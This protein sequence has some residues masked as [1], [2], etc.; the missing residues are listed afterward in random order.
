MEWEYDVDYMVR[1]GLLRLGKNVSIGEDVKFTKFDSKDGA[2]IIKDN[3]ILRSGC[4]IY[5]GCEFSEGVKIGHNSIMMEGMVI[6]E[7]TYIGA[8]VNCEGNSTIGANCGINAQCHITKF[9]KIG[10]YTFFGPMVCTTNDW[11]MRYKRV[12]HAQHLVGPRIGKGVRVGN[13]ATILPG[14]TLGDNCLIGAGSIVTKDV[15]ENAIQYGVPAKT[16]GIVPVEDR[17]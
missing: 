17:L 11:A 7:N 12:G 8:L 3:C 13:M 16:H 10:D 4:V 9:T 15:I 5:G 2:I 14:V 6:G 1:T